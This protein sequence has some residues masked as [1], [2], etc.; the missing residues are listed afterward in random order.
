MI[1][2]PSKHVS[3]TKNTSEDQKCH[4][5]KWVDYPTVNS[6]CRK[7]FPSLPVFC[8]LEGGAASKNCPG[9]RKLPGKD[10][11]LTS[12]ESTCNASNGRFHGISLYHLPLNITS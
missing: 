8:L 4:C 11:Y 1:I 5:G 9:A 7:W 10:I 2:E 3:G 6:Y 12:D